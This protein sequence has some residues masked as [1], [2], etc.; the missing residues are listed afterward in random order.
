MVSARIEAQRSQVCC[1]TG[2]RRNN[3]FFQGLMQVKRI[4]S[5][6]NQGYPYT[7]RS[8]LTGLRRLIFEKNYRLPL[9]RKCDYFFLLLPYCCHSIQR[10]P[11]ITTFYLQMGG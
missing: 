5:V 1:R 8:A 11:P 7:P 4:A 9:R 6:T 3:V 10:V 2:N